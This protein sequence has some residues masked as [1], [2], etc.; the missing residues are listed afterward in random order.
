MQPGCARSIPVT[1]RLVLRADERICQKWLLIRQKN[2][3]KRR[4]IHS[5]SSACSEL[6]MRSLQQGLIVKMQ[7]RS[8]REQ[9]GK[10][11]GNISC[12]AALGER[13]SPA[14]AP[15]ERNT[16]MASGRMELQCPLC[17]LSCSR[18]IWKSFEGL[19]WDLGGDKYIKGG[20]MS[21][22]FFCFREA[23]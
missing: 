10:Y 19:V 12:N 4:V 20:M 17:M 15:R 18:G 8:R 9:P 5:K 14:G 7:T 6:L 21:C 2:I 3:S 16:G 11:L 1:L 13:V 22:H 23:P